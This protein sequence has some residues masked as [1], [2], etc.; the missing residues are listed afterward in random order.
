MEYLLVPTAA[1]TG[2]VEKVTLVEEIGET[3]MNCLGTW[4]SWSC[5]EV[6]L[7]LVILSSLNQL[8]ETQVIFVSAVDNRMSTSFFVKWDVTSSRYN[9]QYI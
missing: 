1:G 7:A 4:K 2:E 8:F 9:V 6:W 5:G 3:E